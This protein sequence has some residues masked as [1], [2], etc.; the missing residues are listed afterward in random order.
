[1]AES[2]FIVRVP[3]AEPHVAHLRERFDP[4]ALLGVPAHITLLYPFLSP[5]QI[6]ARQSSERPARSRLR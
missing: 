5:E 3:E 1:M 4:M 2:A 6:A